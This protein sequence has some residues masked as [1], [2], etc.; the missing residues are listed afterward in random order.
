MNDDWILA[1]IPWVIV[2]VTAFVVARILIWLS[3]GQVNW[4]RL[5]CVHRC[6]NGSAQSM[7]FV[8]TLPFFMMVLMLIVQVCQIM[9][10]NVC[11]HQAAYASVRSAAVWIPAN[12]GGQETANRISSLTLIEQSTEGARY[13]VVSD[14][15]SSKYSKIKQAAVLAVAP[16]APSRDFGYALDSEGQQTASALTR[17]YAGLDADSTANSMIA[18]RL[19]NKLAYAYANTVVRVELMHRPGENIRWLEPPLQQRYDVPPYRDEY[20]PNEAGWQDHLTAQVTFHVPLLPGPLRFFSSMRQRTPQSSGATTAQ[21]LNRE[22]TSG[23]GEEAG[24]FEAGDEAEMDGA[25]NCGPRPSADGFGETDAMGQSFTFSLSAT[26]TMLMEG[27]KPLL[28]Y[29]QEEF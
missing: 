13:L 12:L 18:T 25:G 28:M 21:P 16:M 9:M 6:E 2:L 23:D 14:L 11:V 3:Q 29:R 8:L 24:N 17:L 22:A 1:N 4:Q 10:A 20:Y 7:S 5:R 27:R 15:D 19:R 26:A